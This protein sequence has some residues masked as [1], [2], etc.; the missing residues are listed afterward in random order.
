MFNKNKDVAEAQ[1]IMLEILV[2]VH[3]VCVKNNITYWLQAGTLL[4]AIRHKGFIPWDDDCD[5]AM[6]RKDYEKFL[7]IASK[8][9]KEDMFLQ[10]K[11]TDKDYPLPWAKVRKNNTIL[12]EKGESGKENYHHGV[13]IDIFPFD[14]YSNEFVVQALKWRRKTKD[15]KNYYPKRSLKRFLFGIYA[16]V[17]LFIPMLLIKILQKH[18]IKNHTNIGEYYTY[19]PEVDLKFITKYN[20]FFPPY[21]AANIFEGHSF[22]LPN[23]PENTLIAEYGN[24]YM[25]LPP[26]DRR[27]THAKLIKISED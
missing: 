10:T 6:P 26:I 22:Y 11:N 21:L 17:I 9:L 20:D 7:Q 5:I 19:A 15:K 23:N 2:E 16:N 14:S 27:K 8:E 1:K 13:F 12:I 18:L 3:R 25:E 4:G 24:N